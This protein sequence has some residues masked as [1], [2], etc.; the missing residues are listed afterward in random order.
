LGADGRS[1]DAA[2]LRLDSLETLS[3]RFNRLLHG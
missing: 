2:G 1:K 3:I